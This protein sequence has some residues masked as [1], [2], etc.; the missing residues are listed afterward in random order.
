MAFID[1]VHKPGHGAN[2]T[3]V[4][5]L[6]DPLELITKPNNSIWYNGCNA[7]PSYRP[8]YASYIISQALISNLDRLIYSAVG[9]REMAVK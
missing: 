6:S 1:P 9:K 7:M 4:T 3:H 8:P 5:D 2:F